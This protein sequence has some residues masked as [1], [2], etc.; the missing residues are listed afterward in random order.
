MS[1]DPQAQ[2]GCEHRKI[3]WEIVPWTRGKGLDLGCGV[4]KAY[5][6]FIGVDNGHH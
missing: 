3:R 1:W 4:E 6:H 2:Q 5:P